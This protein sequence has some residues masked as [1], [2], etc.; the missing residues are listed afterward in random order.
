MNKMVAR[1][2]A[3]MLTAIICAITAV[4]MGNYKGMIKKVE[5][6][7]VVNNPRIVPDSSMEAGQK[8][9]WDCIWFGNY[10]QTEVVL[11]GSEEESRLEKNGSVIWNNV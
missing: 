5:A 6:A 7:T 9:T 2:L 1:V 11:E 10:P 8:V 3:G 4:S